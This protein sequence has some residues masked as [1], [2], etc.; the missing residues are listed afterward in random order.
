MMKETPAGVG[1]KEGITMPPG[2]GPDDSSIAGKVPWTGIG[3]MVMGLPC[4]ITAETGSEEPP[5]GKKTWAMAPEGIQGLAFAI[6]SPSAAHKDM[7]GCSLSTGMHAVSEEPE[8]HTM[9]HGHTHTHVRAR[10]HTHAEELSGGWGS[11]ASCVHAESFFLDV[12]GSFFRSGAAARVIAEACRA[13]AAGV[14][15]F[16]EEPDK[17]ACGGEEALPTSH[18]R[19]SLVQ[20][21][22]P[23]EEKVQS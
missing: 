8:T 18:L 7:P 22:A 14:G 3:A 5:G 16:P 9:T 23:T 2:P 10:A 6:Q 19:A 11:S 13:C 1:D 17:S 15:G 4:W 20:K 12:C 21:A